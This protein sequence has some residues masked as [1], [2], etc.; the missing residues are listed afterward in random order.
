[1]S[2]TVTQARAKVAGLARVRPVDDPE[3][4]DARRALDVAKLENYI[5]RVVGSAPPLTAAQ[6]DRLTS[7][8]HATPVPGRLL[9]RNADATAHLT[10]LEG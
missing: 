5:E 3:L 6:R 8:L 10:D 1:M 2:L 9:R 4:A 7:L